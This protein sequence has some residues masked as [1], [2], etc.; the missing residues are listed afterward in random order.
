VC[1][2]NPAD[3]SAQ[4]WTIDSSWGDGTFRLQNV[5]NG[6]GYN[7]DVHPGTP[8]FMSNVL[9]KTPNQPAQHWLM[10]SKGVINDG[11]Y[12]TAFGVAVRNEKL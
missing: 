2:S 1:L 12:S 7:L 11:A 3:T 8:V 5:A 6:T 4:E 9:A 10:M